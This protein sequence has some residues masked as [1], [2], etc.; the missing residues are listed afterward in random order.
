MLKFIA[1]LLGTKSEK[2]IKR[3]M[4]LVE[5]TKREG[6]K[7]KGLSHDDLGVKRQRFKPTSTRNSNPS[8]TSWPTFTNRCWTSPNWTSTKKRRSSTGSIK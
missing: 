1:K 5:E 2:D 3:I 8:M 4:P 7:L 6:E